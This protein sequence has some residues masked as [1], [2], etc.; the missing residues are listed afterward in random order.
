MTRRQPANKSA[1]VRVGIN[2]PDSHRE[3]PVTIVKTGSCVGLRTWP[4]PTGSWIGGNQKSH[5]PI[6]PGP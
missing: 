1:A 2:T 6:S 4:N 5:C 3:Y